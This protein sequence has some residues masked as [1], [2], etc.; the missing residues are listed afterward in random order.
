[1]QQKRR[2]LRGV[3]N[4]EAVVENLVRLPVDFRQI[5]TLSP[6]ALIERSG[7]L[8]TP[9]A[10]TRERVLAL[11]QKS[12]ELVDEWRIWSMDKRCDGWGFREEN[13]LYVVAHFS[14]EGAVPVPGATFTLEDGRT[15]QHT[16]KGGQLRIVDRLTF[17]DRFEA[18]AEFVL[19]EVASIAQG[20][21]RPN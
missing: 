20:A 9:E 11:L 15:I 14:I 2:P 21:K 7:Y 10:V 6:V 18:C 12:P 13:G 17:R 5:G 8:E 16:W 19:R 4:P 1:M 3:V